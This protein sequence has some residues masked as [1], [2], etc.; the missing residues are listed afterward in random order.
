MSYNQGTITTDYHDP[1]IF[2]E[3]NR[4][5]FELDGS[6]EG[7]LPNMRLINLGCKSSVAGKYNR[8]MGA[9]GVIKNIRLMD[10]R[11]ELSALRQPREYLGFQEQLRSNSDNKSSASYEKRNALGMEIHAANET[12]KHMYDAPGTDTADSTT[13]S[14]YLDLRMVFPILNALPVLPTAV[15]QNLKIEIEFFGGLADGILQDVSQTPTTVRPILA[16]DS[17]EDPRLLAPLVKALKERGARWNEIESDRFTMRGRTELAGPPAAGERQD[18]KAQSMGYIGKRVERL[19]L[20]KSLQDSAEGNNGND[21]MGYAN[22]GSQ[23]LL[24]QHTQVRLNGK[25]VI[26]GFNGITKPNERLAIVSDE[27]GPSSAYPG[28]VFYKWS[29]G[30]ELVNFNAVGATLQPVSGKAFGGALSYDCVR[31]GARVADLAIS[32]SR[33]FDAD[34]GSATTAPASTNLPLTVHMYAE[35]DKG[36]SVAADGSYRIVYA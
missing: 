25:N 23:A 6:K 12:L 4:A 9:L 14:G 35:V 34:P 22:R 24:H 7:Y 3:N 1:T 31:I 27:Y 19:L 33:E 26:P 11:T 8:L 16:V 13:S 2:V 29:N 21:Q 15:F 20:V 28:S 30:D 17:V 32:I 36:M 5:V 10:G 18:V